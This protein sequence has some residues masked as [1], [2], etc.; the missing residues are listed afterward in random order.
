[1]KIK[2]KQKKI[3][4]MAR[5]QNYEIALACLCLMVVSLMVLVTNIINGR[6]WDTS[7]WTVVP[8]F[9][10]MIAFTLLLLRVIRLRE[11]MG[12]Q[13]E[14]DYCEAVRMEDL[15]NQVIL[16]A[17]DV[18]YFEWDLRCAQVQTSTKWWSAL[19]YTPTPE[20]IE[21][22]SMVSLVFPGDG[23]DDSWRTGIC[24]RGISLY[25]RGRS[26]SLESN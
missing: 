26:V 24:R 6:T 15:C 19:G 22:G 16:D 4:K 20:M 17:M 23:D 8:L 3:F 5:D 10:D 9:L 14:E 2:E 7:L 25:L 11:K 21:N 13:I 12:G 18:L 1:M